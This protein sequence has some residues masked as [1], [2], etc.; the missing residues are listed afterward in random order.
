[1]SART[2]SIL[3]G[4]IRATVRQPK[5]KRAELWASLRLFQTLPEGRALLNPPGSQA[6]HR[7]RRE[8]ARRVAVSGAGR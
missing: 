3:A 8:A 4:M 1:M 2:R 5:S 7:E 6:V